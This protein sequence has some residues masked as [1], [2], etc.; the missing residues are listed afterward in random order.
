MGSRVAPQLAVGVEY[1]ILIS[2]RPR[3]Q[4]FLYLRYIDDVFGVWPHGAEEL[5]PTIHQHRKAYSVHHQHKCSFAKK[6][7]GA[8]A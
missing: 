6:V 2:S 1:R 7:G 3:P 5:V 4:P 8:K